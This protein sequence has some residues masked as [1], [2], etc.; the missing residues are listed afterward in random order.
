MVDKLVTVGLVNPSLDPGDETG[1][2]FK[3]TVNSLFYQLLGILAIGRGDL[4]EPCFNVR[5]EMY[6]HTPRVGMGTERVK[7]G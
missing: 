5:C 3:H 7:C 2:A 1:V 6:F 4:L